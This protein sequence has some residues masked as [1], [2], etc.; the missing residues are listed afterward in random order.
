MHGGP[1]IA[2]V[3]ASL[4]LVIPPLY[5]LSAYRSLSINIGFCDTG[6]ASN[7][8]LSDLKQ[9]GASTIRFLG[10]GPIVKASGE[11]N[12]RHPT[13]RRPAHWEALEAIFASLVPDTC[14]PCPPYSTCT[15][16]TTVCE[17]GF[18][19]APPISLSLPGFTL[20]SSSTT[21][22]RTPG[23]QF[24]STVA[25][26]I[27]T[28]LSK[29]LDGMPGVGPFA[30]P[31]RCVEDTERARRMR[32]IH[33]EVT[34]VLTEERGRRVCRAAHGEPTQ[35]LRTGSDIGDA[36]QWGLEDHVL[37]SEV[38]RRLHVSK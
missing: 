13:T 34:S 21:F 18:M 7:S 8:V 35:D 31:P 27:Y 15:S 38:A 25:S 1:Y 9:H 10:P 17:R 23:L 33:E 3:F 12:A 28:V 24:N 6:R 19:I 11:G 20:S 16:S 36:Q 29:S 22:S 37:E 5:L 32:L 14:T 4:L 30:F 26:A 2:S